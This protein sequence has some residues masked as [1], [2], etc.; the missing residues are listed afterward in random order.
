M[1]LVVHGGIQYYAL[2]GSPRQQRNKIYYQYQA[3]KTTIRTKMNI[4]K[5]PL[6]AELGWEL[7][8]AFLDRQRFSF[9]LRISKISNNRLSKVVFHELSRFKTQNTEWPYFSYIRTLFED[10]GLDHFIEGHFQINTFN[11]FFVMNNKT[12]ER[13]IIET[14][15]TFIIET[16][17][18]FFCKSR[19]TQISKKY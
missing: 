15:A 17:K 3:A 16:Y 10:V 8:N 5:C 9:F 7:I 13:E 4:P 6:L 19:D 2:Y 1:N 14:K 11:R 18:T 12:K